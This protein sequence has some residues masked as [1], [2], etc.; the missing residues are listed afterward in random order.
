M[1]FDDRDLPTSSDGKEITK[2]EMQELKRTMGDVNSSSAFEGTGYLNPTTDESYDEN[3]KLNT[4]EE[5]T[6]NGV[7]G[8]D[9]H[10]AIT[11]LE[12]RYPKKPNS[13]FLCTG[14]F[15]GPDTV[16]TAGHCLHNKS[17]GGWAKSIKVIPGKNG[18]SNPYSHALGKTAHSVK[19]WTE[20]QDPNFDYGAIKVESKL[21]DRIGWLGY[22]WQAASLS[23]TKVTVQ[24]YPGSKP[25]G[26]MWKDSGSILPTEPLSIRYTIDMSPGQS[27]GPVYKSNHNAVGINAWEHWQGDKNNFIYNSGTRITKSVFDNISYWKGL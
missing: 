3:E 21:G 7:I 25:S 27:G 2:E 15:V 1:A 18:K 13:P 4:F 22:E 17:Q 12:I 11:Y 5:I 8:K 10:R 9:N 19:G 26:T 16:V 14:F 24:G 20:H 23:G 6:L